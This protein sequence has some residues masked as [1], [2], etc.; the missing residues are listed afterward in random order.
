MGLT[1]KRNLGYLNR[2]CSCNEKERAALITKPQ[3]G[4]SMSQL[5]PAGMEDD[6][7]DP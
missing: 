1:Q 3:T 7:Q 5:K 4:E 6:T 2:P